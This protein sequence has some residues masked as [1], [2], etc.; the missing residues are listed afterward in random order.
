MRRLARDCKHGL[1]TIGR[2]LAGGVVKVNLRRITD[3]LPRVQV[4]ILGSHDERVKSANVLMV[5]NGT[6]S[7]FTKRHNLNLHEVYKLT[8]TRNLEHADNA[9]LHDQDGNQR[10]NKQFNLVRIRASS[11]QQATL[12]PTLPK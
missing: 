8:T 12:N 1:Y 5:Y 4:N 6:D 2:M 7:S 11:R 3:A 9:G 10:G